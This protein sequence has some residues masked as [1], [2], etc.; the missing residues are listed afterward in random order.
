[1]HNQVIGFLVGMNGA[2]DVRGKEGGVHKKSYNRWEDENSQAVKEKKEKTEAHSKG[3]TCSVRGWEVI[4][5]SYNVE[6][7]VRILQGSNTS[8]AE[9]ERTQNNKVG[10]RNKKGTVGLCKRENLD[11]LK[12]VMQARSLPSR[13]RG[14]YQ[15]AI[16]G[17]ADTS[18]N[19]ELG[20]LGS[21]VS[22][23]LMEMGR[24]V[25][26]GGWGD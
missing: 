3:L 15:I 11:C 1:M 14:E 20:R 19:K 13:W 26:L 4:D 12:Q 8:S 22:C 17:W 2:L 18:E 9:T 10:N 23:R 25:L 16:R 21:A 6:G 24:E 7:S 5:G